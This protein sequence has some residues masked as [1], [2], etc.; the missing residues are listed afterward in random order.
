MEKQMFNELVESIKEA[1]KIMK[2]QAKPSRKFYIEE[3]SPK[4]IRT[5]MSL[6]QEQF[7][8]LMNI[9]VHTLRNWEQGR[10]QPEGPAKVLLNVANNHPEVL[11]EM[12]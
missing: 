9:S 11:M 7:A 10:R 4:E 5:K 8:T 2:G 3:P 12:V 1:K 6:S